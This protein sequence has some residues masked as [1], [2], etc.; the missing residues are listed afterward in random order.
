VKNR[1]DGI[2][3][4][5]SKQKEDKSKI[6]AQHRAS[7]STFDS[8]SNSKQP[9]P[10]PSTATAEGSTKPK[11]TLNVEVLDADG[12]IKAEDPSNSLSPEREAPS[13]TKRKRKREDSAKPDLKPDV[14]VINIDV[15]LHFLLSRSSLILLTTGR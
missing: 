6:S 15:N 14:E 8:P 12:S 3:A 11:G 5:F 13:P 4:M 10:S 2:Q 7:P 9:T 1:K